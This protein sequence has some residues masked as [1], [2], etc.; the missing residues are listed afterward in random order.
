MINCRMLWLSVMFLAVVSVIFPHVTASTTTTCYNEKHSLIEHS[1]ICNVSGTELKQFITKITNVNTKVYDYKISVL[2]N[3]EQQG[4]EFKRVCEQ[5]KDKNNT[6]FDSCR[7]VA[8]P[9]VKI[10]PTFIEIPSRYAGGGNYNTINNVAFSGTKTFKISW[11]TEIE[12]TTHGWGNV[13]HWSINPDAWWDATYNLRQLY[14]FNHSQTTQLTNGVAIIN[15]DTAT[16]ITAGKMQNDCDDIVFIDNSTT[17]EMPYYFENRSST[18][19]GCNTANTTIFLGNVTLPNDFSGF[20]AYLYYSNGGATDNSYASYGL[21]WN[22][23]NYFYGCHMNNPSNCIDITGIYNVSTVT[24]TAMNV[25][26]LA[27]DALNFTDGSYMTVDGM[28]ELSKNDLTVELW[29]KNATFGSASKYQTFIGR[30]NLANDA[31]QWSIRDYQNNI[32]FWVASGFDADGRVSFPEANLSL[33]EWNYIV[34]TYNNATA[35]ITIYLNGAA[36][37][38]STCTTG[39][40]AS[41]MYVVGG[42]LDIGHMVGSDIASVEI[43]EVRVSQTTRSENWIKSQYE[44]MKNNMTFIKTEATG[45]TPFNYTTFQSYVSPVT[46]TTTNEFSLN[47]TFNNTLI[48]RTSAIFYY[49]G[50]V[51]GNT[52]E[53]NASNN[54]T[55]YHINIQAP[56]GVSDMTIP[57]WWNFTLYYMPYDGSGIGNPANYTTT[58]ERGGNQT[59]KALSMYLCDTSNA[60]YGMAIN[61]STAKEQD[62]TT[63]LTFK[64]FDATFSIQIGGSNVSANKSVSIHPPNETT[65]IGNDSVGICI[66]TNTLYTT[67]GQIEYLEQ[68][69]NETYSLRNYYLINNTLNATKTQNITLYSLESSNSSGITVSVVDEINNPYPSVYIQ[70]DRYY[71]ADNEYRTVAIGKTDANGQDR[72]YLLAYDGTYRFKILTNKGSLIYTSTDMRITQ[73]SVT[74]RISTESIIEVLEKFKAVDVYLYFNTSSNI[75]TL[76]YND[77]NGNVIEGCL[78]ISRKGFNESVVFRRCS[79]SASATITSPA[80]HLYGDGSYVATAMFRINP[81]SLQQVIYITI[82]GHPLFEMIGKDGLWLGFMLTA[83]MFMIGL[84]SPIMSVVLG[85]AGVVTAVMLGLVYVTYGALAGLLVIGGIM[86]FKFRR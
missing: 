40:G 25:T 14:E 28:P 75:T 74:F 49:N 55:Y 68:G 59:I 43:D 29:I 24:G 37:N 12:Q 50:T 58:T 36:M 13:G 54:N 69:Y 33:D 44:L 83:T 22:K 78:A 45:D 80:L 7:W 9:V 18:N 41:C 51:Y 27:G 2:Q 60:T 64:T 32:I 56:N 70:A 5:L 8:K 61:F 17:T 81:F 79:N 63:N 67:T 72:I 16:L 82:G 62:P 1:M 86:I 4:V 39:G 48:N 71:P 23:S 6:L 10:V 76:T 35:N 53:E 77:P 52:N 38:S 11:K 15:I 26:G 85:L 20:A 34:G 65:T 42:Y 30:R 57:F 21:I 3:V 19:T 46:V 47:I 73:A 66:P 31:H 84:A